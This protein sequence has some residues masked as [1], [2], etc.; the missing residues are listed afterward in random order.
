MIGILVHGD[1]HFVVEGVAAP[2]PDVARYLARVWSVIQIGAAPETP[3]WTIRGKAFREDL[4]WAVIVPAESPHSPAVVQLLREMSA[5]GI[6][7]RTI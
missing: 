6:A 4:Q 7:P 5:R 3:G 1:N 2:D